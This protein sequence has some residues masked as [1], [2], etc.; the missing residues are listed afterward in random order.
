MIGT[1]SLKVVLFPLKQ[2][3]TRVDFYETDKISTFKAK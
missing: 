3:Y 1:I 2:N